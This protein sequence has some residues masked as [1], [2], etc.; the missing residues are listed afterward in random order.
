MISSSPRIAAL[1]AVLSLLF[2]PSGAAAEDTAASWRHSVVLYGMGAAIDGTAQI[3]PVEVPVDVSVSELF[4]ALEIGAMGAYRAENGTWSV[5]ADAT[6]MGLGGTASTE[7]GRVKGDLD[8]DQMTLMGTVGRRLTDHLEALVGLA[9]FDLSTQLA[10]SGPLDTRQAEAEADWVDPTVGLAYH[11]PF[12]GAWR[13]NLRGDLGGFGVGS[14]LLVHLLANVQWQA[15]EKAG[16]L[17]GYRYIAFD[18]E[19]GEGLGRQRYDLAQ[20]GP[21]VGLSF[22]F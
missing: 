21:V 12:A 1:A 18:Y 17:F 15:T 16:L 19:D 9:Y 14:D 3:G 6:F 22:S 10:T 20:Q 11:R 2:L 5:T 4:D 7:G 13:L 8:L